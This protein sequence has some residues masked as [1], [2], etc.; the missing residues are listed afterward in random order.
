MWHNVLIISISSVLA[1]YL[2]SE[3]YLY[4]YV[5]INNS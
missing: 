4:N 5:S 3:L 1:E 2:L